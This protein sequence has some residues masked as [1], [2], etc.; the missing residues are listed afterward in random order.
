MQFPPNGIS[1]EHLTLNVEKVYIVDRSGTV[2]DALEPGVVSL[3]GL[4]HKTAAGPGAWQG[5]VR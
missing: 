4:V 5:S 3:F 1:L 2:V